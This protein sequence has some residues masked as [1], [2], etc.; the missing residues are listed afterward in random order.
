MV[1]GFFR[2]KHPRFDHE[3]FEDGENIVLA[4]GA[5]AFADACVRLMRD[6]DERARLGAAGRRTALDVYSVERKMDEVEA[7]V[8]RLAPSADSHSEDRTSA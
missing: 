4:D 3:A 7:L 8:E 5:Q 1:R 2:R 6:P